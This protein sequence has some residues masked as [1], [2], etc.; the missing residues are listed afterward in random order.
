MAT[1]ETVLVAPCRTVTIGLAATVLGLSKRAIEAKIHSGCWAEG[2][3]YH[4][5]RDGRTYIDLEGVVKW[6]TGKG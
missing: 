2:R 3:Q 5:A 1:T 4:R 6:V